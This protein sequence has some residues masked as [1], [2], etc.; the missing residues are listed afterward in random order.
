MAD[1]SVEADSCAD[2][3]AVAGSLGGDRTDIHGNL[4]G[5]AKEKLAGFERTAGKLHSPCKV[6]PGAG[7]NIVQADSAGICDAV[8]YFI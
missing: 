8:Q 3:E 6:V 7:G 2:S 4:P 5:G 1:G